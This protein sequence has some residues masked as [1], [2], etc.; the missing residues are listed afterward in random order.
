MIIIGQNKNCITDKLAFNSFLSE[1]C[2]S[3]V[4]LPEKTVF[5]KYK[6]AEAVQAIINDM[7]MAAA[8]G[9]AIYFMPKD[10]E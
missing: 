6:K 4:N 9:T 8:K 10:E 5:A 3:I 7:A 2:F 1:N